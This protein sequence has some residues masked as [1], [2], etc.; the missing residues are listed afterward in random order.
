MAEYRLA[1]KARDDME[2]T[3]LYSLAQWGTQQAERYIDDVTE[4]FEFLAKSPKAG[5]NCENIRTGYRKHPVI[6]HVIYYR[7][8][9]YG[10]EVIRVLHDRMLAARYL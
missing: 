3:W 1:P 7:E 4:A 9:G 5:M 10:I 2:A 8:T 6:R